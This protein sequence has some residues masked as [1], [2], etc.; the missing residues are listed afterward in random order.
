M[1]LTP[2][3]KR[4]SDQILNVFE[5]GTI[6]G[7]YSSITVDN[8]GPNR[9]RQITYGRCHVAEYGKLHE[10]S[11]LYIEADGLFTAQLRPYLSKVGLDPLTDDEPFK[12]L[13]RDAGK[14][15]AKMRQVQDLLFDKYFFTPAM[16][17]ADANQ[18]ALPLSALVICD[19]YIQ[20]GSVPDFLCKRFAE[21]P[22]AS[23]GREKCWVEQYV[24]TR[25]DWL[26]NHPNP[27]LHPMVHR[28]ECF[29][30]EI[31]RGNWDLSQLPIKVQGLE[32]FGRYSAMDRR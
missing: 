18:M 1:K 26:A 19:S 4:I 2:L 11:R 25:E 29:R 31:A 9:I 17:W 3:Q 30:Q 13:L 20:S 6:F 10:L 5:T 22:P 21:M 7:D 8:S 23:G 24:A 12:N 32:I 28:M 27:V 16:T 14:N 15:D